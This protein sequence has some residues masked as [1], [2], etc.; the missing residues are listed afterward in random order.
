MLPITGQLKPQRFTFPRF[1]WLLQQRSRRVVDHFLHLGGNAQGPG[2]QMFQ[3]DVPSLPSL[4]NRT[5]SLKKNGTK[6]HW[7]H[8]LD[9][10]FQQKNFQCRK[11]F[12]IKKQLI[13]QRISGDG[14]SLH[15]VIAWG[16]FWDRNSYLRD[17]GKLRRLRIHQSVDM[18]SHD[19]CWE[20]NIHPGHRMW[21]VTINLNDAK[22]R[23]KLWTF[24][25]QEAFSQSDDDEIL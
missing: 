9:M 5:G 2:G 24:S 23:P 10:S 6:T 19:S 1:Q 18:A 15:Q 11:V 3:E 12:W 16:F 22:H 21:I 17:A 4:Q 14:L 7:S 13:K 25:F 20:Q 8:A